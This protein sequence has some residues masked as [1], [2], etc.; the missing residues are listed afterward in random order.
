M[1]TD[2]LT[3]AEHALAQIRAHNLNADTFD[4]DR[5]QQGNSLKYDHAT[6][7]RSRPCLPEVKLT[8]FSDTA[9]FLAWCDYLQ[10][11]R[12]RVWR[13]D[14]AVYFHLDNDMNELCWKVSTSVQRQPSRPHLP[15]IK[16]EWKRNGSGRPGK[17]AWISVEELRVTLAALE[18]AVAS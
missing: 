11:T 8:I 16:P 12:V 6:G 14:H 5:A 4:V 15:G 9:A 3:T 13:G 7:E 2:I 18:Q 17:D 10:A 1:P